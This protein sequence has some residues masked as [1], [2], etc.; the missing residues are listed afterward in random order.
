[1]VDGNYLVV[2]NYVDEGIRQRIE[3]GEYIDFA[4][5]LSSDHLVIEEDNRMEIVNRNGKTYFSNIYTRRYPGR[6]S[7]LIQY[8]H[9][10]HTAALLY[11]WD[12]V[13]MY[14]RDFRLHISRYPHRSWAVILQQAWSMRLKDRNKTDG[15]QNANNSTAK[16]KGKKD[17]C[18]RYNSGR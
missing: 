5:L 13:Y 6:A 1:M 17:I 18:W 11:T 16:S 4:R 2:G 7:E 9:I 8:N 10:I 3:D 14:G 15:N 12:N